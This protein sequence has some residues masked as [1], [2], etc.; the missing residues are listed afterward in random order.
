MTPAA[1]VAGAIDVLGQ[2]QSADRPLDSVLTIWA[3]RNRYAGSTDR[4]AIADLCYDALRRWRSAAWVAGL[5]EGPRASLIGCL[6]LDGADPHTVFTGE[7]HA[8]SPLAPHECVPRALDEAPEAVAFDLQD[9]MLPEFAGVP[10]PAL[11]MLRQRAP[12]DLRVNLLKTDREAARAALASEGVEAV[13]GPLSPT[14]LRVTDGR[15]RLAASRA[16]AEGLIEPMDAASQAIADY[17]AAAPGE[18][19]LDFCAGA[20]GKTLALAAAMGNRGRLLAHDVEEDRLARLG[21]RAERAGAEFE[22][23]PPGAGR[24]AKAV[25]DLTL[26]DAPCSGSGTWRRDPEAKWRLDPHRLAELIALQGQILAEA[27]HT[28]RLG[29]R[30]VYVTCSLFNRE[31]AVRVDRFLAEHSDFA[32]EGRPLDLTPLDGGDGFFAARMRRLC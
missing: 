11:A 21:P 7:R 28:V 29:G 2:W 18:T 24:R 17:A 27:A 10:R 25:A 15:R 13:P 4:R 32:A 3:R 20:G 5:G 19:V 22:V 12:V 1:R 6:R 16:L 31:N 8:P 26:V 23:L 14:A 30:L 9:W